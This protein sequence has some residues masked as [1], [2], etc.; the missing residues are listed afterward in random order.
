MRKKFNE[1]VQM[2]KPNVEEISA[3]RNLSKE[4][5]EYLIQRLVMRRF[6]RY[7]GVEMELIPWK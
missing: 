2:F 1:Y 4:E 5:R 7:Y 6:T 3:K